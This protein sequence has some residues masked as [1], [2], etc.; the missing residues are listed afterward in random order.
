MKKKYVENFVSYIIIFSLFF[1]NCFI[2]I[3]FALKPY[4]LASIGSLAIIMLYK[5][6]KFK[7]LNQIDLLYIIMIIYIVISSII[8]NNIMASLR[9]ILGMLLIFVIYFIN[10]QIFMNLKKSTLNKIITNVSIIY[11]IISIIYYFLGLLA[12][13]FHFVGNDIIKYGVLMDRQIPRLISLASSDPNI[14]SCYFG[15]SFCFFLSKHDNFK[16]KFALFIYAL[17]IILTLSRG[18]FVSLLITLIYYLFFCKDDIKKTIINIIKIIIVLIIV[19]PLINNITTKYLS[20]STTNL[21][22]SRIQSLTTDGGSGRERLWKYALDSFSEHPIIGIGI[23]NT[24][25]YNN[26]NYNEN[27]YTHNTYL[28]I[29]SE[30]GIIG[31]I[32]YIIIIYMIYKNTRKYKNKYPFV[33]CFLIF[34][35]CENMFLSLFINELFFFMLIFSNVYYKYFHE[36]G[37]SI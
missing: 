2:D 19:V 4:M 10:K 16:E 25:T 11:G 1:S 17:L 31:M 13:D 8:A 30:L 28:E 5:Y 27:H 22:N 23:N 21:I 15:L 18:A 36:E 26:L 33:I 3:G 6:R 24:L 35:L 34:L 7:Y 12:F 9:Y 32:I 37:D 20:F 29:L 14:S